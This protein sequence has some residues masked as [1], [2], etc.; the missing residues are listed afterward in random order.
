MV[1]PQLDKKRKGFVTLTAVLVLGMVA[2]ITVSSSLLTSNDNFSKNKTLRLSIATR[3]L[4]ES[5]AE[6]A[7]NSLKSNINYLGNEDIVL[8]FGTCSILT[9]TGS[10]NTNRVLQTRATIENITRELQIDIQ[11]INPNTVITSWQELDI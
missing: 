9:I 2:L 6:I 1:E 3:H 5:C 10:G 8:P 7:L 11:T 4:A